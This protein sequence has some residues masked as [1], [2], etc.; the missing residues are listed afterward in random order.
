MCSV[1]MEKAFLAFF[2]CHVK[3]YIIRRR[4]DDKMSIIQLFIIVLDSEIDTSIYG[5]AAGALKQIYIFSQ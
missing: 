2:T 1:V 4:D 3:W 5:G